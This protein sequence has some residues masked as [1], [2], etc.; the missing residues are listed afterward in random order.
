MT[1]VAGIDGGGS[2]THCVLAEP[3]GA[4]AGFAT[5]GP[6]NWET[7]GLRGAGDAIGD[8]LEKALRLAGAGRTAGR[9]RG[10]RAGRAGLALGRAAAWRA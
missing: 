8:A 10:L 4:V 5:N 1:L 2:K 6:G 7:V 9:R 3:N